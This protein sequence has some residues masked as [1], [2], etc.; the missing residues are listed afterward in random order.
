[1]ASPRCG[2]RTRAGEACLSPAVSG[3]ARCRMHGGSAG[4]GAP[5]GNQNAFKTGLNTAEVAEL[6]RTIRAMLREG[7]ILLRDG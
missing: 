3:K 1:M 6:R 5:R 2:A 4:S 7:R